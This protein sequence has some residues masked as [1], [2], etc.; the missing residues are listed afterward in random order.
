[1]TES[2]MVRISGRSLSGQEGA[3]SPHDRFFY[4]KGNEL[5]AVRSGKWKLHRTGENDYELYDLENDISENN[6]MAADYPDIVRKLNKYMNDFDLEMSDSSRV[7]PHGVTR[8]GK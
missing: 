6:N 1:M 7:R 4:H 3:H 8:S 2:S 5:K